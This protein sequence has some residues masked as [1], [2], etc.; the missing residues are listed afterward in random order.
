MELLLGCGSFLKKRLW[1]KEKPF[2]N[3][4]IRV[5]IDPNSSPDILYDLNQRPLPFQDDFFDEVHAYDVLEHLGKQG[6]WKTFFEEFTEY[7]RVLKNNGHM[8]ILVPDAKSIWAW[9]DPGHTRI[10]TGETFTFLDQDVYKEVGESART[11]YRF[12]WPG[13]FKTV[14]LQENEGSLQVILKAIKED[15]N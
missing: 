15:A 14:H 2:W 1:F 7:W 11:D 6:D 3:N 10:L 8:F 5:D 9:G 12:V 13:N 4:V